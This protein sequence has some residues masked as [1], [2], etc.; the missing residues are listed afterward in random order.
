MAQVIAQRVEGEREDADFQD[1]NLPRLHVQQPA[2]HPGDA[3]ERDREGR[4]LDGGKTYRITLPAPIPVNN[5][6]SFMVYDNQTRS[7]LE[8]DQRALAA[9]A[10]NPGS[11]V[12]HGGLLKFIWDG[13]YHCYNPDVVTT[14]Q[15][16]V[17]SG[18][19]AEPPKADRPQAEP[20]R[21]PLQR[22]RRRKYFSIY[23]FFRKVFR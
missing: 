6:W 7:M 14:L 20:P 3:A 12:S 11:P 5:F 4:P 1:L 21:P 18:D 17:R 15:E 8:T 23:E 16:A 13:E 2:E 19:P 9:A 22:W 10:W